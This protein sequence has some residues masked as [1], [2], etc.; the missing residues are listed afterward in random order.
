MA[1]K[2][3]G[4]KKEKWGEK[5]LRFL[6]NF[7]LFVGGVAL[8]GAVVVPPLAAPL[9]AYGAFNVAEA[10]GFEALRRVAKKRGQKAKPAH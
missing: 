10:G 7:N 3:P 6:R 8:A 5:G 4:G 1:E 9:T 2:A